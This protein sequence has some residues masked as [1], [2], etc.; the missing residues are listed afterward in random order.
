MDRKTFLHRFGMGIGAA[1][2][3]PSIIKSAMI[4]EKVINK[5]SSI[6]LNDITWNSNEL[7]IR[8]LNNNP[9][10][11]EVMLFGAKKDIDGNIIPDGIQI[12]V[13]GSSFVKL[14]E[15]LLFHDLFIQGLKVRAKSQLQLSNDLKLFHEGTEG[16]LSFNWFTPGD[17]ISAQQKDITK[18]D[19][20]F[21]ELKITP[22]TYVLVNVNPGEQVDYIFNINKSHETI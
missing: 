7:F 6:N 21:F 2:I 19:V 8:I 17:F 13:A 10:P 15:Y 9:S 5:P 16:R 18:V 20:P 4:N 11:A 3:T 12:F 22:Q 1:I 14:N